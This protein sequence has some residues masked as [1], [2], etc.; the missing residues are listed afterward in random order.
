MWKYED[1]SYTVLNKQNKK[2]NK[3]KEDYTNSTWKTA[4]ARREIA[5]FWLQIHRLNHY[6]TDKYPNNRTDVNDTIGRRIDTNGRGL[7]R[8]VRLYGNLYANVTQ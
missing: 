5:T 3:S 1:G 6:A 2:N 4:K 7:D 8:A